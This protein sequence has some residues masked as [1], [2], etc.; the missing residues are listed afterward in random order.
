MLLLVLLLLSSI[1]MSF[2]YDKKAK[3]EIRWLFI[4]LN[5]ENMQP[6]TE[7]EKKTE[8]KKDKKKKEKKEQSFIKKLYK[9]EGLQGI[10][11]I[12]REAAEIAK[13]A[14]KY[15][16][17]HLIIK[18]FIIDICV[19]GK[20]AA[21]TAILYGKVCAGVYPCAGVLVSNTNCKH[22]TVNIYL[23]FDENAKTEI[24]AEFNGKI[25]LIFVLKA[26]V[27]YGLQAFKLYKNRV[28][29]SII[30]GER[31]AEKKKAENRGKAENTV[32]DENNSKE[33]EN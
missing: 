18:K 7:K 1:H 32:S 20:D 2:L 3:Y 11:D 31:K 17:K 28:I 30:R 5:S 25:K 8:D 6:K 9:G 19:S 27:V 12:L 24:T 23:D 4:S 16:V 13:G 22:Y 10:I 15:V 26:A 33:K 14:F 21:D 29:P